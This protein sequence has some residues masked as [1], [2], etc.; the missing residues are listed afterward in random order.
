VVFFVKSVGFF[1]GE[2]SELA[3]SIQTTGN[4][5][6]L[7]ALLLI[8]VLIGL[9]LLVRSF[10]LGSHAVQ[11]AGRGVRVLAATAHHLDLPRRLA[12]L[13][14]IPML[15]EL[16]TPQ[17]EAIAD[18]MRERHYRPGRTI[19]REGDAGD[20]FFL[21]TRGAAEVVRAARLSEPSKLT[22]A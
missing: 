16:P 14:G 22:S 15:A 19:V 9:P 21:I 4:W 12:A 6:L 1:G 20:R 11:A 5:L 3:N 13:A 17:L 2:L 10:G 8:V 18:T 7:P